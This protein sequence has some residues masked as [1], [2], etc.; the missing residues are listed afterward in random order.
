MK[1]VEFSLS[2]SSACAEERCFLQDFQGF[3]GRS[4][5]PALEIDQHP[6]PKPD[7]IFASLTRGELLTMLD[8]SL[9]CQQLLLDDESPE[10]VTMNMHPGLYRYSCLL[11]GVASAPVIFQ[12]TMDQLLN[13]LTGVRCYL[14][15]NTITR[16]S[17]EEHRNDLSR[18]LDQL[19]DKG[20]YL[21]EDK[22]YFLQSL[23]E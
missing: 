20:S 8:S 2:Y 23:A 17:T 1:K 14:D 21:K 6:I 22:C 16:K 3:Q 18:V 7:D 5:C 10:L 4:P 11:F 13:G 12:R 9:A 15:D 19:Q